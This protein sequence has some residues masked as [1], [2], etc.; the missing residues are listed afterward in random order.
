M[1]NT[2]ST[3]A[4]HRQGQ[5]HAAAWTKPR[6]AA[7]AGLA[8]SCAYASRSAAFLVPAAP[9]PSTCAELCGAVDPASRGEHQNGAYLLSTY[10]VKYQNFELS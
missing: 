8:S 9:A 2:G 5:L 1:L 3:R 7:T 10:R 6:A 4:H